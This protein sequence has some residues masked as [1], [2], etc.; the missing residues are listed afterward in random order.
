MFTYIHCKT[1]PKA[2]NMAHQTCTLDFFG[3][4][5]KVHFCMFVWSHHRGFR[6][7]LGNPDVSCRLKNTELP[8]I[9]QD[10]CEGHSHD[11]GDGTQSDCVPLGFWFF[12]ADCWTKRWSGNSKKKTSTIRVM[13][14]N[15]YKP[16]F[17]LGGGSDKL[18]TLEI[19]IH[20]LNHALIPPFSTLNSLQITKT[21]HS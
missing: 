11:P 19:T 7:T 15:N 6:L 17:F 20:S 10:D 2:S 14:H 18:I 21:K 5:V 16:T 12:V 3:F 13:S 1:M 4:F 9:G 8:E